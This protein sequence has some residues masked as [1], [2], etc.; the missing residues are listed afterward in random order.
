MA[1]LLPNAIYHSKAVIKSCTY[2]DEVAFGSYPSHAVPLSDTG[3]FVRNPSVGSMTHAAL[4][5]MNITRMTTPY[6][7]AGAVSG[8]NMD[9]VSYSPSNHDWHN[10]WSFAIAGTGDSQTGGMAILYIGC[11]P[12]FEPNSL[13]YSRS[14][15]KQVGSIPVDTILSTGSTGSKLSL[16]VDKTEICYANSSKSK[17]LVYITGVSMLC[18][19]DGRIMDDVSFIIARAIPISGTG[20]IN[21]E[22]T[23]GS[24]N[25]SFIFTTDGSVIDCIAGDNI[26]S[27]S[28]GTIS[29]AIPDDAMVSNDG[30]AAV[31]CI[32]SGDGEAR[33][34]GYKNGIYKIYQGPKP[35]YGMP[36]E[37]VTIKGHEFVCIVYGPFYARLS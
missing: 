22:Q 19:M 15:A 27:L 30:L 7:Y 1:N 9:V 10:C 12:P 4:C 35:H 28:S 18:A 13:L 24:T 6:Y 11:R 23:G 20:F 17:E 33:W 21:V 31:S 3:V 14:D 26:S 5:G 37:R 8:I 25:G 2:G 32:A 34:L 16:T 36:G 29:Q